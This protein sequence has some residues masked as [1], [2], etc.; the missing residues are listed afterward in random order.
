M[1]SAQE[2][3]LF[4]IAKGKLPDK[5]LIP[6]LEIKNGKVFFQGGLAESLYAGN[7]LS[8]TT[9]TVVFKTQQRI[10]GMNKSEG[11]IIKGNEEDV[12]PGERQK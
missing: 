11:D 8:N 1:N 6:V 10:D 5:K 9:K 12:K 3:T 7:E 2:Q 4:G